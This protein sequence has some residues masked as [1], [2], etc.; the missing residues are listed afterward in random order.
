VALYDR[1]Y[2]RPLPEN[3]TEPPNHPRLFIVH[4]IVG[5]LEA[6]YGHFLN[7]S[8][9]ESHF[10]IGYGLEQRP[11]QQWLDT[12]R[13]AD[14]NWDANGISVTVETAGYAHEPFTDFQIEE[15]VQLGV[16]T[17]W[18]H[19]I[20]P[21]VAQAWDGT[22]LGWHAQFPEWN[23]SRKTCP[24]QPRIDQLQG[25]VFPEIAR[26]MEDEVMRRNDKAAPS[27]DV[28]FLQARLNWWSY[29]GPVPEL[30]PDGVFG[31]R[32]EDA[33]KAFQS[34]VGLDPTGV[35]GVMTAAALT[36]E[37]SMKD[38]GKVLKA[39]TD[40]PHEGNSGTEAQSLKDAINNHDH[41]GKFLTGK[42]RQKV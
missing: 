17:C 30:T 2:W 33:V 29:K 11:V 9:S 16:W 5:G 37:G 7:S 39:H 21:V 41:A 28:E 38:G 13:E 31:Q 27:K 22:G 25:Y 32:T 12:D 18:T 6:A 10:G 24:G 19:D 26:R 40:K 23:R 3:E 14:T 35:V 42:P 8:N 15:L 36:Y 1:A 4:V 34:R 20:P